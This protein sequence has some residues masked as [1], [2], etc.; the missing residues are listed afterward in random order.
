M[1]APQR[2]GLPAARHRSQDA[3]AHIQARFLGANTSWVLGPTLLWANT[4]WVLGP[5]L[6]WANTPWGPTLLGGPTLVGPVGPTLFGSQHSLGPWGQHSFWANTL[7]GPTPF[8]GQH[9]LGPGQ[10]SLGPT[11]VGPVGP[12]LV[13]SVGPTLLGTRSQDAAAHIRACL[14]FP[15]SSLSF[16]NA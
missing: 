6:L 16:R 14:F 12:T 15:G 13:W 7:W 5:T 11:L 8:G 1:G 2:E 10:H 9:S 3:A 4:P